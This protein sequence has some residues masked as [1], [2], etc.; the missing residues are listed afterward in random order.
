[1]SKSLICSQLI[2]FLGFNWH[3]LYSVSNRLLPNTLWLEAGLYC[4]LP[5]GYVDP[6]TYYL[7]DGYLN[8]DDNILH[9]DDLVTF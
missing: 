2:L 6:N 7:E 4:K 1:M 3:L 9:L 8:N 5:R